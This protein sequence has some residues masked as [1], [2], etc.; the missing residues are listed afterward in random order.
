MVEDVQQ[1]GGGED[2]EQVQMSRLMLREDIPHECFFASA[3]FLERTAEE[4]R[5]L[6]REVATLRGL[7]H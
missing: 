2:D 4:M 1:D 6:A 5:K 3:S 7:D